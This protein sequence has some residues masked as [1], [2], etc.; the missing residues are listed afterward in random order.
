MFRMLASWAVTASKTAYEAPQNGIGGPQE[1][2]KTAYEE[3]RTAQSAPKTAQE[4]PKK[5]PRGVP[6]EDSHFSKE[7]N[8]QNSLL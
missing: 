6:E 7:G 1:I 4:K 5:R 2:S 3:R 8:S